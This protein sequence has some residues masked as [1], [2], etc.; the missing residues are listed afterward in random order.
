MNF[1]KLASVALRITFLGSLLLIASACV[2]RFVNFFGYTILPEPRY[3]S[4]RM[5]ELAAVFLIA[6]I[7]LLLR[8]VRDELR[9]AHK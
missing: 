2:E 7:A 9:T 5:L 4:G 3:S 8:E 1:E 6:V